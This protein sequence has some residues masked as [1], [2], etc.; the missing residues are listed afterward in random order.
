MNPEA[1][2]SYKTIYN[3]QS[4]SKPSATVW[5]GSIVID[6]VAGRGLSSFC[7]LAV[8]ITGCCRSMFQQCPS[9]GCAEAWRERYDCLSTCMDTEPT[10][11]VSSALLSQ[12][13][14]CS[15]C[16]AEPFARAF[17]RP[18]SD[19]PYHKFPHRI[20]VQGEAAVLFVGMN[21][22]RNPDSAFDVCLHE[23]VMKSLEGFAGF[24]RNEIHGREYI[25]EGGMEQ[26]YN[27]HVEI[28]RAAFP[29]KR[30]AEV[31]SV[32][33]LFLCAS[34]NGTGL[35]F[36]SSPCAQ[37]YLERTIAESQPTVI[38]AVGR[39]AFRYF[40]AAYGLH[41]TPSAVKIAGRLI[42]VLSV[43]H[44]NARRPKGT[45]S[46]AAEVLWAGRCINAVLEGLELPNAPESDGPEDLERHFRLAQQYKEPRA[47]SIK[48]GI[49]AALSELDEIFADKDFSNAVAK[50]MGYD[51]A[52]RSFGMHTRFQ[53]IEVA[54]KAW[55]GQLR[56][57]GVVLRS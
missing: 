29:R 51:P 2:G 56:K 48:A 45:P 15:L 8:L 44:P 23:E 39:L 30:F 12:V 7:P 27:T 5:I 54:V 20:G 1:P 31:A 22:R 14:S 16:E 19:R 4:D 52:T 37:R 9:G 18:A 41:R 46:R 50:A 26:H 25:G 21:P 10:T 13:Y 28:V 33:E 17:T 36:Q 24:S 32:T 38:I 57:E 6:R 49:V 3:R 11:G 53:T 34:R 43:L 55:L 35:P 47:G 42:T 40:S